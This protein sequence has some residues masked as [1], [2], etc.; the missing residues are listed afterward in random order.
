MVLKIDIQAYSEKIICQVFFDGIC[1]RYTNCLWPQT[2]SKTPPRRLVMKA[3]LAFAMS[4]GWRF[5][6]FETLQ[7]LDFF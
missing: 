1:M 4:R 3:S 6:A 5:V 2:G 7:F